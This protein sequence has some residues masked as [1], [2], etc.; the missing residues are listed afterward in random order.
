[1]TKKVRDQPT[2]STPR[3]RKPALSMMNEIDMEMLRR[4]TGNRLNRLHT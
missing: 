2:I 1:M 3:G 4:V